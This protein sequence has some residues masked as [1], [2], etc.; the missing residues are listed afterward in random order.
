MLN[1]YFI[2][3]QKG[4]LIYCERINAENIV[5]ALEIIHSLKGDINILT[6]KSLGKVD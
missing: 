3:Y 6:I 5:K 4:D 1:R 2:E